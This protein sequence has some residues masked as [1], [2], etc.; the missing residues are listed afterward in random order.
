[1]LCQ[2]IPVF[3]CSPL[4][5]RHFSLEASSVGLKAPRVSRQEGALGCAEQHVLRG[6]GEDWGAE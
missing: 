4:T 6:R 2:M 3:H 1:M 5:F